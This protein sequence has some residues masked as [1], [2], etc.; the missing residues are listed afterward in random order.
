M[1]Q[2]RFVIRPFRTDY[3]T[4]DGQASEHG[5][6]VG[7]DFADHVSEMARG[8]ALVKVRDWLTLVAALTGNG[9]C[10]GDGQGE[11]TR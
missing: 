2:D 7:M 11:G 10:V 5:A 9:G 3:A 6:V 8:E 1:E 4:R